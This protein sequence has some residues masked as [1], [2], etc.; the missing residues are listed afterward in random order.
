MVF[1]QLTAEFKASLGTSFYCYISDPLDASK[2][3]TRPCYLFP[4]VQQFFARCLYVL[5]SEGMKYMQLLHDSPAGA[6]RAGAG[7]ARGD[8][9][10]YRV[11]VEV[12]L[13]S[14]LVSGLTSHL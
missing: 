4:H 9:H 1:I 14:L 11:S 3:V 12:D 5:E 2:N 10:N 8:G 7:K 6:G 13:L